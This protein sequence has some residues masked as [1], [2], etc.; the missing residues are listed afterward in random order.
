[1]RAFTFRRL[2]VASFIHSI[3][4]LALLICAFALSKPEPETF[5]LGMAHGQIGRASCRERV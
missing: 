5:V 2:E 3:V 1:M 4:F